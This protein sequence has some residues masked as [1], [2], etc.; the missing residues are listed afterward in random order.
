MNLNTISLADVRTFTFVLSA[1]C[2]LSF[3]HRFRD[4]RLSVARLYSANNQLKPIRHPWLQANL[5]VKVGGLGVRRVSSLANPAYLA[6]TASTLSLQAD[7]L[8]GCGCT[9]DSYL[10]PYLSS[11]SSSF[12]PIPDALPARQPFWDHPGIQADRLLVECS[13]SSAFHR[14]SSLAASSKH[15]FMPCPLHHVA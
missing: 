7:I 14:A 15:S 11:W 2:P 9:D 12:V 1:L 4:L 3:S 10:Q 6:S 8:S 13:L 5:P